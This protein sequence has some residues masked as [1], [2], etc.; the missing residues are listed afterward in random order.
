M[1]KNKE[2]YYFIMDNFIESDI[3]AFSI[4]IKQKKNKDDIWKK[5]IIFPPGWV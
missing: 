5:K 3:I 1:L 4:D 2:Q